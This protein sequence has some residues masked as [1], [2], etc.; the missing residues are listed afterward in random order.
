MPEDS[1]INIQLRK[2]S[3]ILQS[4]LF[5]QYICHKI[6]KKTMEIMLRYMYLTELCVSSCPG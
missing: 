1:T 6:K 4:P 2:K 5:Y 3:Q